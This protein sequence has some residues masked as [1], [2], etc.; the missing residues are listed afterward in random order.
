VF[1]E[2]EIAEGVVDQLV[3][4]GMH[5]SV[6]RQFKYRAAGA[7]T[8]FRGASMHRKLLAFVASPPWYVGT[9]G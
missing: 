5:A 6:A 2:V 1:P 8:P 3:P 7:G 4:A 9:L